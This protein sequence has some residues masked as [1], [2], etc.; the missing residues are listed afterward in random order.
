MMA[1]GL[2]WISVNPARTFWEACQAAMM[3]QLFLALEG[4]YPACAFG[5]FDQYT[6]PFLKSDL[7]KGAITLDQ[8]QEIVDAFFLKANCFTGWGEGV[9]T[10][11]IGNTYQHDNRRRHTRHRRDATNPVHL[12]CW[13]PWEG[14]T[15]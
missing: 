7:E 10:Q 13:R 12:W 5:R 4:G 8:A 15:A 3:Y 1:D 11:G 9:N 2:E 6:W 14:S